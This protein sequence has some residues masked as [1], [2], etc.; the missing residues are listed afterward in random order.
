M[1]RLA[2]LLL[3]ATSGCITLTS[4][5]K[6]V[7]VASAS[8]DTVPAL[9]LLPDGCSR[10]TVALKDERM[11][12]QEIEGQADP[13]RRQRNDVGAAGGNLLL[14]LKQM[15]RGQRGFECPPTSK[16]TDCGGMS[17]AWFRIEFQTYTCSADALKEIAA[18][19]NKKK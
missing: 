17:G 15:E 9:R 7:S 1:R 4:Q 10:V 8:L 16:I 19:K 13:F 11:S 3:I 6:L 18:N 2:L 14:V 5:G 12:E